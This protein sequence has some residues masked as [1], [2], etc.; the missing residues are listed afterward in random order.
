MYARRSSRDKAPQ[1]EAQADALRE[2]HEL[3]RIELFV[4]LGLAGE[5]DAQH[6]LLGGLDAGQHA[7]LLEHLQREVLRLVDDQQHLA[8]G[9]RTA[10]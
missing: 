2:L 3:R 4:E 5:N 10:R 6:L 8:A 7:D 1:M 9:A